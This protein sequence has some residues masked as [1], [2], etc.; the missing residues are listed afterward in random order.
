MEN[1]SDSRKNKTVGQPES[2]NERPAGKTEDN[3]QQ[4]L[5]QRTIASKRSIEDKPGNGLLPQLQI[6]GNHT[7]IFLPVRLTED[8]SQRLDALKI[9]SDVALQI[10]EYINKTGK[11]PKDSIL[12]IWRKQ[13]PR[14]MAFGEQHDNKQMRQF[15]GQII[16]ELK[17]AGATHLALE[18]DVSKEIQDGLRRFQDTGDPSSIPQDLKGIK[19]FIE[20][21]Q[22]ARK[23]GIE[24]VAI[25]KYPPAN[26]TDRNIDMAK[27]IMSYLEANTNSRII[28][29]LGALHLSRDEVAP[30]CLD[31][32]NKKY[33]T[34]SFVSVNHA[35]N[36]HYLTDELRK[37][38]M[39]PLTDS[40]MAKLPMSTVDEE[41]ASTLHGAFDYALIQPI[42]KQ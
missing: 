17:M 23:S 38:V 34:C 15:G 20:M 7:D 1:L 11:D 12:E 30:S 27:N 35:L 3:D 29:W 18:L 16:R 25:D 26:A 10:K 6:V 39:I 36:L 24:I 31:Y 4:L 9:S 41:Y 21:L 37:P 8:E 2:T 32:V 40:P 28:L 14:V 33:K 19:S 42:Q 5:D 13:K 22:E